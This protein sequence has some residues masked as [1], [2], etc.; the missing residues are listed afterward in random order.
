[1][2]R[3]VALHEEH[4]L[5][6]VEAGG[7]VVEDDFAGVRRDVGGVGVV[8]GQGVPVGDE[9]V[10]LVLAAVLQLDP[11]GEGAHVVAEVQLAGGAHAAEDARAGG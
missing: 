8:G 2:L 11:V 9:E 4:G 6:R 5:L 7:E 10:A 1:M 3:D